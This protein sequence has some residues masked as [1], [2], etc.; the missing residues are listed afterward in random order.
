M[1]PPE[2]LGELDG[3][4]GLLAGLGPRL[5][6]QCP[7]A[8]LARLRLPGRVQS[9]FLV[10]L[11]N[12]HQALVTW[13]RGLAASPW[14]WSPRHLERWA[15]A[16]LRAK[17]RPARGAALGPTDPGSAC[18]GWASWARQAPSAPERLPGGPP[19]PAACPPPPQ[20][21]SR[22]PD[23]LAGGAHADAGASGRGLPGAQAQRAQLLRH[24]L[25]VSVRPAGLEGKGSRALGL[26]GAAGGW[27]W[28]KRQGLSPHFLV[29][30]CPLPKTSFALTGLAKRV[31]WHAVVRSSRDWILCRPKASCSEP[32]WSF[33]ARA[34]STC[35]ACRGLVPP[36]RCFSAA[37]SSVAV[38]AHD[39]P[40]SAAEPP[41]LQQR[42][43]ALVL[44]GVSL[45]VECRGGEMGAVKGVVMLQWRSGPPPQP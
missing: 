5:S 24:L 9:A 45:G 17:R 13:D 44:P 22:Q 27:G 20:V 38:A 7:S 31:L 42:S 1:K 43:E 32:L 28:G 18:R 34:A 2:G 29:S 8:A 4:E 41:S 15:P 19:D 37:R 11:G 10:L 30:D 36:G 40:S 6:F 12:G 25:P 39:P 35:G 23:P 3:G 21:V 16:F 33:P 14:R 26:D